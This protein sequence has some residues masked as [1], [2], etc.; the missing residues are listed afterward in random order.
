MASGSAS[1]D[2]SKRMPSQTAIFAHLAKRLYAVCHGPNSFGK[3][4][5]GAPVFNI[6]RIALNISRLPLG[7]LP[8]GSLDWCANKGA[9]IAHFSSDMSCLLIKKH[10]STYSYQCLEF[11]LET[12]P[13]SMPWI[14]KS[15]STFGASKTAICK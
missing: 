15:L 2:N 8:R 7:G 1:F 11:F 9:T 10:I 12:A 14:T 6:Q 5:Q 4:R 13:N 3:S